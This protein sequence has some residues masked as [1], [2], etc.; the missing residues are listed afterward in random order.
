MNS[1]DRNK[2][3]KMRRNVL[4][5]DKGRRQEGRAGGD[6]V[7]G[8]KE[9]IKSRWIHVKRAKDRRASQVKSFCLQS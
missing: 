1:K 5:T 8:T 2:Q 6:Q 3:L 7:V 9:N 4:V